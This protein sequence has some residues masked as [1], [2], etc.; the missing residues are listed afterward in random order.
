MEF[1]GDYVVRTQSDPRLAL[2]TAL[3][4][5][6]DVVLLDVMM[7]DMDGGEVAAQIWENQRLKDVPI[8]YQT[9]VMSKDEE[10]RHHGSTVR[11]HFLIKPVT[12]DDL[13]GTI[14]KICS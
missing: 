10:S 4:F 13:I 6:P 14:E 7:P 1:A 8:I 9:A 3:E 11:E 2:K 5:M 12:L